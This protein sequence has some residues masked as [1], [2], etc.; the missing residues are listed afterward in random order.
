MN[1]SWT[2]AWTGWTTASTSSGA[3]VKYSGLSWVGVRVACCGWDGRAR[4]D[5]TVLHSEPAALQPSLCCPQSHHSTP[6]AC[7]RYEDDALPAVDWV[8]DVARAA[9]YRYGIRGLVI[10]VS[11]QGV[12]YAEL[13]CLEEALI[14]LYGWVP[15]QRFQQGLAQLTSTNL[16]PRSRHCSHTTSWTTSGPPP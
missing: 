10:D 13:G 8:L 6:L 1:A 15:Y 4:A 7:H 3:R 12:L 2:R 14:G 16:G 5:T 9:V 11:S